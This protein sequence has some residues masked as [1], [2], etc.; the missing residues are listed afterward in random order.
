MMIASLERQEARRTV[1][2]I[3][4]KYWLADWTRQSLWSLRFCEM[5]DIHELEYLSKNK[6]YFNILCWLLYNKVRSTE[7]NGT[8]W[9]LVKHISHLGIMLDRIHTVLRL[10]LKWNLWMGSENKLR[11]KMTIVQTLLVG[12]CALNIQIIKSFW[13]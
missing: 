6:T 3:Y 12:P 4:D 13:N 2:T 10:V 1:V 7:T 5:L 8:I 9:V 11:F